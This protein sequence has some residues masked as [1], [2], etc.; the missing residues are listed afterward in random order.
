[1]SK[2]N[3]NHEMFM[4]ITSS[5]KNYNTSE[6]QIVF[7]LIIVVCF[8]NSCIYV[9]LKPKVSTD[10]EMFLNLKFFVTRHLRN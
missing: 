10:G 3:E 4:V 7:V 5:T 8:G 6:H 1:M 2:F 9:R